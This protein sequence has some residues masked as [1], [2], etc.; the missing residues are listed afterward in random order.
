MKKNARKNNVRLHKNKEIICTYV[1][2]VSYIL[3]KI[4]KIIKEK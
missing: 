3:V 4:T 1:H 2:I